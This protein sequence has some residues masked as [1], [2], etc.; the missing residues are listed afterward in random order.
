MYINPFVWILIREVDNTMYLSPVACLIIGI[1]IGI[2]VSLFTAI[3]L[4]AKWSGGND[5]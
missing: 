4:G 3:V 2:A 1:I 5:K